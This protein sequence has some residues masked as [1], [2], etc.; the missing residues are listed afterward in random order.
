MHT[1]TDEYTKKVSGGLTVHAQKAMLGVAQF[2]TSV[3][4]LHELVQLSKTVKLEGKPVLKAREE[5]IG[6]NVGRC[7]VQATEVAELFRELA[8]E[9]NKLIPEGE[10]VSSTPS[11]F[12]LLVVLRV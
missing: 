1:R 4:Y 10:K 9:S 12:H 7:Q 6:V 2:I 3:E 11:F 8:N 5:D